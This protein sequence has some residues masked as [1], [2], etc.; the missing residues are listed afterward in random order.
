MRTLSAALV[1]AMLVPSLAATAAPTQTAQAE[2]PG[3]TQ[4]APE[5]YA[6]ASWPA[7]NE[8][9]FNATNLQGQAMPNLEL[10]GDLD[11]I[12]EKPQTVG[13]VMVIEFWASWCGPCR[14]AT[15]KMDELQK[16]FAKDV[17]VV[18]VSGLR[19][20]IENVKSYIADN[21]VS[22]AHGYDPTT[23]LASGVG[24]RGIPHVLVVSTDGVIRWQGSPHDPALT[25]AV[26]AAVS[27][28]PGVQARRA[29][30]IGE[31]TGS[32]NRG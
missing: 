24:V 2:L 31:A 8:G 6:T 21:P 16:T 30:A 18:A 10:V 5:A 28:D 32:E 11:W 7:A 17:Q 23:K 14:K 26:K 15:P 22:Y 27:V 13:K 3:Y 29:L 20:P 4:P 25:E 1:A 9:K 19:D 12:G